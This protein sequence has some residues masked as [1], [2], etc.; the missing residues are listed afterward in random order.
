[1]REERR[2]RGFENR[3]S[4]RIFGTKRDEVTGESRK[5]HTEELND[6]YSSPNIVQVIK[7][8]IMRCAGHVACMEERRSTYRILLEKPVGKRPHGRPRH[9]WE[10]NIKTDI[11]DVRCGGMDW[12]QLAQD[13]NKRRAL[14]NVVMNL[15]VP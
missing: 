6:L 10:D 5:L 15:Q 1:L 8:R 7:S 14:V 3:M 2:L 11:Q 13:I 12:I 9:R 4:R